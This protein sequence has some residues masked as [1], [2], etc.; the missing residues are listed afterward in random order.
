MTRSLRKTGTSLR[1]PKLLL[2]RYSLFNK[3]EYTHCGNGQMWVTIDLFFCTSPNDFVED[4]KLQQGTSLATKAQVLGLGFGD[5][6]SS[7]SSSK[8]QAG[9]K[10]EK[11]KRNHHTSMAASGW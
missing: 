5:D 1:L 7:S 10:T 11:K 9:S 8:Q 4:L 2:F 6:S 3:K